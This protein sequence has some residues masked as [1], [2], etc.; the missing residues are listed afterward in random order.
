M[1]INHRLVQ[2]QQECDHL[3]T[4]DQLASI[5][6]HMTCYALDAIHDSSIRAELWNL[7][8]SSN[9]IRDSSDKEISSE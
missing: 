5:K 3:L 9:V 2:I 7:A 8:G 4:S 1:H 6:Y